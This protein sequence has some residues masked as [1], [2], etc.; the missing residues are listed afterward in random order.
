MY[1]VVYSLHNSHSRIGYQTRDFFK[2]I[3]SSL[4]TKIYVKHSVSISDSGGDSGFNHFIYKALKKILD[5][6]YQR[7]FSHLFF[8]L[9]IVAAYLQVFENSFVI[10]I[11]V[12][13][14]F[15]RSSRYSHKSIT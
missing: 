5:M 4:L 12:Y 7:K 10:I 15:K 6:C 1:W 14:L 9:F 2:I 13:S 8:L 11:T 3:I